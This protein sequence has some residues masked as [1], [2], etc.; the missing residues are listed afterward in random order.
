MLSSGKKFF[1]F[2]H[3]TMETVVAVQSIEQYASRADYLCTLSDGCTRIVSVE[4]QRSDAALEKLSESKERSAKFRME[5]E[6]LDG[7]DSETAEIRSAME[8]DG[9]L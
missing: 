6:S 2:T 5:H 9:L 4:V 8:S 7:V 1:C 3:K